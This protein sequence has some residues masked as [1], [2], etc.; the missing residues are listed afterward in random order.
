MS[1]KIKTLTLTGPNTDDTV[2]VGRFRVG[3]NKMMQAIRC[4]MTIKV[5]N[6]NAG[7]KTLSAALK[8]ALLAA[9]TAD[10]K[11]GATLARKPYKT[12]GFDVL[13]KLQRDCF[14]KDVNGYSDTTS[15]LGKTLIAA[16]DTTLTIYP[17]IPTGA[18]Y[19]DRARRRFW[20]VGRSQAKSMQLTIKRLA[21]DPLTPIDPDLSLTGNITI[22]IIP[23]EA[24]TKGDR[25]SYFYEYD[26][27]SI[28]DKEATFID[29]LPLLAEER[30]AT[31]ANTT[32]SE[33]LVKV[34]DEVVAQQVSPADYVTD[35]TDAEGLVE[36]LTDTNTLMYATKPGDEL[37]N[38]PSGPLLISE[39]KQELN[40]FKVSSFIVPVPS[41]TEIKADVEW[42]ATQRKETVKAVS[43][44]VT[45]GG[46]KL[47]TRLQFACP[48]V[49]FAEAESE[50][51]RYAGW[52]A[53]P[54]GK[55]GAFMP[56]TA[57]KTAKGIVADAAAHGEKKK[58]EHVVNEAA[59]AIP[60][61]VQ[62]G[63][64]GLAS[65]PSEA[66]QKLKQQIGA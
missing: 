63:H 34:G 21:G 5:H 18:W 1:E 24:T 37:S 15:G 39:P 22:D 41:E 23:L 47:P 56:H 44:Y 31:Q 36:N 10:L 45:E 66:F 49:F 57:L 11:Y 16:G 51:E 7:T 42:V 38:L 2:E 58:A 13:R 17:L 8:L 4:K 55:A 48:M 61:V 52:V 27:R 3:L 19:K 40:P 25:W 20:G 33:I 46:K 60:G 29:G 6:A 54:E 30:T 64:G 65:T 9:I 28:Q 35:Y 26:E 32:I 50:Y 59:L 43:S 53:S 14:N 62:S 12:L